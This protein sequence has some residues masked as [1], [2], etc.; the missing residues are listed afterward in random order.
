VEVA[1]LILKDSVAE[2]TYATEGS[3]GFDI[4][5]AESVEIDAGAVATVGT[6]LVIATPPGWSLLVALRSS[7]PSRF[8][9][10]QPHGV[11][12]VDQDYRG[13]QDE[14]RV[15]LMNVRD[16]RTMI[17]AGSR[18]AQGV[19]VRVAQAHWTRYEPPAESRG[20]F[21]STN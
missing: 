19:F 1:L 20:G 11:G 9:V 18:I 6:G 16:S 17:P 7:T 12:I 15:Q 10:I 21:G 8:G 13:P 4:I 5:T 14:I 3:V 2:P